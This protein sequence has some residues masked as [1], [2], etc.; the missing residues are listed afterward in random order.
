MKKPAPEELD[1]S[2]CRYFR[3]KTDTGDEARWG[4]CHR[5]PPAVCPDSDSEPQSVQAWVVLP[6]WCGEHKQ[7]LQ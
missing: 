6:H 4:L 5:F 7:V 1:C 3:E 2:G